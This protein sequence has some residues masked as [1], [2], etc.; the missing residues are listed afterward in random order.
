MVSLLGGRFLSTLGTSQNKASLWGKRSC[1]ERRE[2]INYTV[3]FS[4]EKGCLARSVF[5]TVWWVLQGP[6]SSSLIG[7]RAAASVA[8]SVNL[9]EAAAVT[10]LKFLRRIP[11]LAVSDPIIPRECSG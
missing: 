8:A 2:K 4:E 9:N 5:V 10:K 7:G 6:A 11:A 3:P 1:S